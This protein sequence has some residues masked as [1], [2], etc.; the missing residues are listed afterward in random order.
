MEAIPINNGFGE[1]SKNSYIVLFPQFVA[2]CYHWIANGKPASKYTQLLG[3]EDP[4][5]CL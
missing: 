2:R 5:V 4:K 1:K 3:S